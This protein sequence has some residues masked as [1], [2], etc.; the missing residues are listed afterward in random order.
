MS[1]D[2]ITAI[3]DAAGKI[4]DRVLPDANKA[5]EA[6][7]E[8]QRM[9]LSGELAQ[10]TGQLEINKVEAGSASL[11]VSGWRPSVGWVCSAALAFQFIAAPL[12]T[13]AAL[14]LGSKIAF[15]PLDTGTLISLL[16]ALLGIGGLRT[17]EKLNGV[18]AK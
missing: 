14:L 13:W 3:A 2:P 17:L 4:I 6:K 5:A 10:V 7:A 11:F 15:P 16:M 1:F 8:L 18:A 9:R 12:I